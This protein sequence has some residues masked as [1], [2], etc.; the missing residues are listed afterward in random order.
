MVKTKRVYYLVRKDLN[1]EDLNITYPQILQ[2]KGR[3]F[4]GWNATLPKSGK[5]AREH[6]SFMLILILFIVSRQKYL[7]SK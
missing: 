4:N 6:Q 7:H 2:Q 1:W 3:V 5:M